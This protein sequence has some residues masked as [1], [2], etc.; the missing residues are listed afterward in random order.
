MEPFMSF[1]YF[2]GQS[3]LINKAQLPPLGITEQHIHFL[4][5]FI[6]VFICYYLLSPLLRLLVALKWDRVLTYIIGSLFFLVI[7]ALVQLKRGSASEYGTMEMIAT[8]SL[9]IIF[10]GIGLFVI[11][12]TRSI[13]THLKQQKTNSM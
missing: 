1:F 4:M 9:G 6:G 13:L 3:W 5:G 7:I 11:H 2:N 8:I 10:F 12:I